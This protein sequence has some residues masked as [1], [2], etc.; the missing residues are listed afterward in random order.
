MTEDVLSVTK[1]ER[2]YMLKEVVK[3]LAHMGGTWGILGALDHGSWNKDF[4]SKNSLT[5]VHILGTQDLASWQ[6]PRVWS[7]LPARVTL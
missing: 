2:D 3:S 6:G 1:E 4:I 7:E 5:W